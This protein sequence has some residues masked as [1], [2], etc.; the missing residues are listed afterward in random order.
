MCIGN[1]SHWQFES[2]I[3]RYNCC[4]LS[5]QSGVSACGLVFLMSPSSS[6]NDSLSG[7]PWACTARPQWHMYTTCL[8]LS[9]FE[10][11]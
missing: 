4:F 8:I 1:V 11:A 9:L 5:S 6:D 7:Q 10:A 2:R 3:T